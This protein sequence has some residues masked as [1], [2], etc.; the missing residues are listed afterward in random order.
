MTRARERAQAS[1][2]HTPG[3]RDELRKPKRNGPGWAREWRAGWS[4]D[5]AGE[6][7]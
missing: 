1:Y 5:E 3:K 6:I 2:Y 7:I 4:D